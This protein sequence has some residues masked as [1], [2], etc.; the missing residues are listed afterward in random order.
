MLTYK[1]FITSVND[2]LD[3]NEKLVYRLQRIENQELAWQYNTTIKDYMQMLRA[4]RDS[5]VRTLRYLNEKGIDDM[6][7]Y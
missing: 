1:E 5:A 3:A 4:K 7:Y 2:L 6:P